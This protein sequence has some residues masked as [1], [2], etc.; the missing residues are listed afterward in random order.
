MSKDTAF[1]RDRAG[2][3]KKQVPWLDVTECNKRALGGYPGKE[4]PRS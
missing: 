2:D 4:A 3:G 1:Q